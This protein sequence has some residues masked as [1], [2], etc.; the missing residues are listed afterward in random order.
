MKATARS[1]AKTR[2]PLAAAQRTRVAEIMSR[3]VITVGPDI[4]VD[5]LVD[6]FIERGLSRVPVVD[7]SGRP[8]GMVAKTD[9][10]LESH[11]RGDTVEEAL[12]EIP[13]GRNVRYSPVGFHLHELGAV[14][15]DVMNPAVVSLPETASVAEAARVMASRH[16]HGVPVTS[17]AGQVVGLLSASDVMGWVAG[18]A[19]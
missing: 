7:E 2:R 3:E 18:L 4:N 19:T 9:V 13:V 15:R 1:K 17:D 16:L 12:P 6:L 8:I 5:A 10:L 14:V 11:T